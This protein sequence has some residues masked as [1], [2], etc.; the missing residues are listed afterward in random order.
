MAKVGVPLNQN[1]RT[2]LLRQGMKPGEPTPLSR[3]D[4]DEFEVCVLG[5]AVCGAVGLFRLALTFSYLVPF[6]VW[7][8]C[9]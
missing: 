8:M 5:G 1:T 6:A 4:V 2:R 9:L 7:D 3:V